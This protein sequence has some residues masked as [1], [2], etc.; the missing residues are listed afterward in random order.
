MCHILQ[1]CCL[2]LVAEAAA[3]GWQHQQGWQQFEI[4]DNLPDS[5]WQPQVCSALCLF[6]CLSACVC[7]CVCMSA[8]QQ[9]DSEWRPQVLS[10]CLS[11]FTCSA[12]S[13][14]LCCASFMSLSDQNHCRWKFTTSRLM[15]LTAVVGRR[16]KTQIRNWLKILLKP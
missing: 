14:S 10:I 3:V 9:P 7:M 16:K 11:L 4:V 2:T 15:L 1:V 13:M 12:C 6:V 8:C 5:E